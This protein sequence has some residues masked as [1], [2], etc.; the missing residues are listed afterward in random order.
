M[1]KPRRLVQV[2]PVGSVTR[3]R[4]LRVPGQ[5]NLPTVYLHLAAHAGGNR[6]HRRRRRDR[7]ARLARD[8]SLHRSACGPVCFHERSSGA[9]RPLSHLR[10]LETSFDVRHDDEYIRRDRRL[11]ED[12]ALMKHSLLFCAVFVGPILVC[13]AQYAAAGP[14]DYQSGLIERVGDCCPCPPTATDQQCFMQCNAMLPR[15]TP[16]APRAPV[17]RNSGPLENTC[18]YSNQ[19]V[20]MSRSAPHGSPCRMLMYNHVERQSYWVTGRVCPAI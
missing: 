19:R 17:Q 3:P 13:R 6:T 11:N 2:L 8:V 18:C 10:A 16:P 14:N 5:R 1:A 20:A 15:C 12:G 9:Q 4:R 7:S